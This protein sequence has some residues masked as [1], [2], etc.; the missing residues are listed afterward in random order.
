MAAKK[1]NVEECQADDCS[2]TYSYEDIE[3]EETVG[4]K[5]AVGH[6]SAVGDIKGSDDQNGQL[7]GRPRP[8]RRAPMPTAPRQGCSQC[9]S[10][11]GAKSAAGDIKGSDDQDAC[12]SR[13]SSPLPRA[14]R[15]RRSPTPTVPLPKTKFRILSRAEPA[16]RGFWLGHNHRLDVQSSD[17]AGRWIKA[18]NGLWAHGEHRPSG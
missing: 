2:Y 17:T 15:R 11:P 14:W 9:T 16:S 13:S 8:R 10:R 3:T 6:K 7:V 18:K 5:S 12:S 1:A 4:N